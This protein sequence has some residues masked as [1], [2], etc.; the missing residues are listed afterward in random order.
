MASGH[1]VA[2]L[3]FSLLCNIDAH[4][5][6]YAGGKLVLVLSRENLYVDDYTALSVG[7][8]QRSVPDFPR[9][10]A[11]DSSEKPFFGRKL[12]FALR[13]NFTY[14]NVAGLNLCA[15]SYDTVGVKVFQSVLGNVGNIPRNLLFAELSVPRLGFVFFDMDRREHVVLN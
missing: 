5:F 11:E 4:E 14:E 6:V 10:F 13:R 1:L 7:N 9:L 3:N 8:F 2:D 15:Y 12:R